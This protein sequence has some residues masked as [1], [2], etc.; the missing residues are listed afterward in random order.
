M[1]K[2]TISGLVSVWA[3]VASAAGYELVDGAGQCKWIGGSGGNWAIA[4]NWSGNAVPTPSEYAVYERAE[5]CTIVPSEQYNTRARGVIAAAGAGQLT[6]EQS[7]WWSSA[8]HLTKHKDARNPSILNLSDWPIVFFMP[9]DISSGEGYASIYPG[10]I[11]KDRDFKSSDVVYFRAGEANRTEELD[12]TLFNGAFMST[13]GESIKQGAV[14]EPGHIV[15]A[16]AKFD[17]KDGTISVAGRFVLDGCTLS[18]GKIEL[19]EGGVI[20]V[21]SSSVIAKGLEGFDGKI[22]LTPS[23]KMVET[24]GKASMTNAVV[25]RIAKTAVSSVPDE[26]MF[27]LGECRGVEFKEGVEP[28]SAFRISIDAESD[29]ENYIVQ[30]LLV[31]PESLARLPYPEWTFI[32]SLDQDEPYIASGNAHRYTAY[33]A[34]LGGYWWTNKHEAVLAQIAA[35]P[36]REFDL[37][38]VGDSITHRWEREGHGAP[39]YL[40]ITNRL[41]TLNLGFGA[42]GTINC[43]WR[44]RNGELDGYTAKVFQVL[45]GTNDG[46]ESWVVAARIRAV[47][48]EIHSRHPESKI[49]L[50]ALLPRG[51]LDDERRL[52]NAAANAI[53]K[54]LCNDDWLVWAD[55][56]RLFTN[57]DGTMNRDLAWDMLHPTTDGYLRW[58]DA[59]LHVWM[60]AAGFM[61]GTATERTVDES[62]QA[63]LEGHALSVPE[64]APPDSKWQTNATQWG[65]PWNPPYWSAVEWTSGVGVSAGGFYRLDGDGR[66]LR[67]NSPEDVNLTF[68]GAALRC[69]NGGADA[70]AFLALKA[71]ATTIPDLRLGSRGALSFQTYNPNGGLGQVL[72]G[73]IWIDTAP[74]APAVIMGGNKYPNILESSLAGYGALLFRPHT[75][76]ADDS[77]TFRLTLS[78]DNTRFMGDIIVSNYGSSLNRTE[79]AISDSAA[80]GRCKSLTLRDSALF[81]NGDVTISCPVKLE[82]VVEICVA[83]GCSCIIASPLA[84][85]GATLLQTGEGSLSFPDPGFSISI[86]SAYL[87]ASPKYGK[88]SSRETK[89][90]TKNTLW[91]KTALCWS[92][93]AMATTMWKGHS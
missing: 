88:I 93:L 18:A 49:I 23:Y 82:G 84:R 62:V 55:W 64:P 65:A 56:S 4:A 90:E 39:S 24:G 58:R 50:S 31:S 40:A 21:A 57:P 91:R 92:L 43:L 1:K 86:C 80:L 70:P 36:D 37:V 3:A 69:V 10:V 67:M 30:P 2:E 15:R 34:N 14:I 79:L 61:L 59:A 11:F 33:D 51:E 29:A 76:S 52:R 20:E 45:I 17:A 8:L 42:D 22:T 78:G 5:A 27:V 48:R 72:S 19:R 46:D 54:P 77:Q 12:T 60:R 83:K 32:T 75:Q 38:L 9:V 63:V 7:G 41:R 53:L 68:P 13:S 26:S 16:Q 71:R 74:D 73:A 87:L 44:L 6:I 81:I 25:L 85:R 66:A 47:L 28:A 35:Q 89:L